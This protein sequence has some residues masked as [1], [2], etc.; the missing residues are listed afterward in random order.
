MEVSG[1]SVALEKHL[2]DF[3]EIKGYLASA[4]MNFT[5]GALA[6]H[7]TTDEISLEATGAVFNDIFRSAHEGSGKVGLE[8]CTDLVITTPKGLIVMECSGVNAPA[9]L[10]FIVILKEGGNRA[11]VRTI[12]K[13][14][15]PAAVEKMSRSGASGQMTTVLDLIREFAAL[16]DARV[17][18][19]GTL[20]PLFE[21]RWAEL[22]RFYDI[23]ISL[24]GLPRRPVTGRFA[25]ADIRRKVPSRAHLPVPIEMDL[26]VQYRGEYHAARMV[27]LSCEGAF[28]ASDTLWSVGSPLT[29]HLPNIG[30]DNEALFEIVGEVAWCT[31]RA[32]TEAELPYAMDIRF[33]DLAEPVRKKLD[34]LVLET[35]E[36]QLRLLDADSLDP[37]FIRREG[38]LLFF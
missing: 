32:I 21:R 6:S 1:V 19:G 13:K 20:S 33:I 22:K 10:H 25:P 17:R 18:H 9:H 30:R 38:L 7:C 26:V 16:N 23:L 31:E 28:L 37:D 35:L 2:V 34:T 11:L 8:A 3:K 4:I 15:V 36:K 27:N 24:N 12:F 14:V 29:L 5:G